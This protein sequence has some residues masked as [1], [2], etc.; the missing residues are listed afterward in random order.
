MK[1]ARFAFI[2]LILM[3]GITLSSCKKTYEYEF[4]QP[5]ENITSIAF[6]YADPYHDVDYSKLEIDCVIVNDLWPVFLEDFGE[7]PCKRYRFD[8]PNDVSGDVI[9]ISYEDG[10]CEVFSASSSLQIDAKGRQHYTMK[11]FDTD[12]FEQLV[13]KYYAG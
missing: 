9:R 6:V 13:Q 8:P 4:M 11:Y 2:I 1:K 10:S 3:T 12:A 7:I 5:V